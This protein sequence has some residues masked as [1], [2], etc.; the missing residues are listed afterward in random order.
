[1]NPPPTFEIASR[2]FGKLAMTEK[3]QIPACAGMA[4]RG[5]GMTYFFVEY[6]LI[7]G[8]LFREMLII[9]KLPIV[10]K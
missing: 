2:A 8:F 6:H 3:G 9:I 10:T 4:Y 1:M 5:T 7:N